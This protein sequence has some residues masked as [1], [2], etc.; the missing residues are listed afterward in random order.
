MKADRI[1]NKNAGE[2]LWDEIQAEEGPKLD[3]RKPIFYGDPSR[4]LWDEINAIPQRQVRATIYHLCCKLQELE[5]R[6]E[7]VENHEQT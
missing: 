4:R 3:K 2:I 5:A 6:L 7:K 1:I